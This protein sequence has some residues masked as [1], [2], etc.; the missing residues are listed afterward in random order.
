MPVWTASIKYFFLEKIISERQGFWQRFGVRQT[1]SEHF[2]N[3]NGCGTSPYYL[4]DPEKTHKLVGRR[5]VRLD[6]S[7]SSCS[8]YSKQSI[9]N[10]QSMN[11]RSLSRLSRAYS[12]V[13]TALSCFQSFGVACS[14]IQAIK[15]NG[16]A[17][18]C[19]HSTR[20]RKAL[21]FH[22]KSQ[23]DCCTRPSKVSTNLVSASLSFI[24][25]ELLIN[26]FSVCL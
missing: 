21:C 3:T 10:S 14:V 9:E 12:F 22:I 23:Q 15:G 25:H 2:K 8:S 13:R 24:Q 1:L 16:N 20:V 6:S 4:S 11:N 26:R 17:Y 18:N 19:F 5:V 7:Q